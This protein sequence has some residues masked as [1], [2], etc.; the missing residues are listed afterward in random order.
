VRDALVHGSLANAAVAA[1]V[2]L[3][4]VP[5]GATGLAPGLTLA[6]GAAATIAI[7]EP[8]PLSRYL[9]IPAIAVL[10]LVAFVDDNLALV[11]LSLL[12]FPAVGVAD[13]VALRLEA[14]FES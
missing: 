9:R 12:A 8:T 2:L 13:T 14:D 7:R 10:T 6:V 5:L 4:W 1:A 3:V 11:V